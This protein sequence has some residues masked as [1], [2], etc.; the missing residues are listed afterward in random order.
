MYQ[1]VILGLLAA[2]V[3]ACNSPQPKLETVADQ[4]NGGVKPAMTGVPTDDPAEIPKRYRNL[5]EYLG[6]LEAANAPVDRPWYREVQ[7]GVF[8]LQTGNLRILGAEGETKRT[9]TR[10]ELERKFGFRR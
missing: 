4:S 2:A 9:F 1:G 5:D 6:H 7:P 3:V 8:M 10:E